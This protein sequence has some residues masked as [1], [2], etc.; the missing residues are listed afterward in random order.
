[1]KYIFKAYRETKAWTLLLLSTICAAI[2]TVVNTL[3]L[4]WISS[5]LSIGELQ[6]MKYINYII[7]GV[8][9]SWILQVITELC[10]VQIHWVYTYLNNLINDKIL[11]IDV[12]TFNKFSCGQI[13]NITENLHK[14]SK[15]ISTIIVSIRAF[16]QIVIIIV[17]I[18]KIAPQMWSPILI[19]GIIFTL[20]LLLVN[21]YWCKIDSK[22]NSIK[23]KRN[24]MSDEIVNGFIEVRSFANARKFHRESIHQ[25]NDEMLGL[26]TKRNYASIGITMVGSIGCSILMLI[27]LLY[28]RNAILTG[29]VLNSVAITLVIYVFRLL[30]PFYM[31]VLGISD[32]ISE[33]SGIQKM[34]EFLD[35]SVNVSDG[36]LIMNEFNDSIQLKSVDFRYENLSNVLDDI[37]MTIHK[38]QHIGICGPS[39]AGKSSLLKLLDRFYDASSGEVLIDGINIKNFVR[40]SLRKFIGTIHQDVFIFDGTI[41][42]NIAYGKIGLTVSDEEIRDACMKANLWEFIESLEDGLDTNVGSRGLKLSGGQQQRIAIARV[43]LQKP[44]I[45]I[46]DEATASLDNETEKAVQQ[47]IDE[48]HDKTVIM[49]AHRL[50]TIQNCD[51]IYVIDKHKIAESGTHNELMQLNGVYAKMQKIASSK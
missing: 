30:Q 40:S 17:A 15:A 4:Q 10:S 18:I 25:M 8:V 38:G 16:I 37:N 7:I 21:K 41:R 46:M 28:S 3:E 51:T 35:E 34:V 31:C 45:I 43:M 50:S 42:E 48:F 39:G 2:L 20:I 6:S 23:A 32:S 5:A 26:V 27:I 33:L 29:I 24:V 11:D 19:I 14:C 13:V 12:S 36:D 22:C 9:S 44:E 49:I 47:A 1:M